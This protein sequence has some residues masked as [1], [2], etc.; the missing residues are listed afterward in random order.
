MP[1]KTRGRPPKKRLGL[2]NNSPSSTILSVAS[3]SQLE[4]YQTVAEEDDALIPR[5]RESDRLPV[6]NKKDEASSGSLTQTQVTQ[7]PNIILIDVESASDIELDTIELIDSEAALDVDQPST[8]CSPR[9]W[10]CRSLNPEIRHVIYTKNF[11][12]NFGAAKKRG[13]IM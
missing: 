5:S 3:F 2:Q 11:A 1:P 4:G 6:R 10:G 8:A 9:C 12:Q 13:N 7:Q